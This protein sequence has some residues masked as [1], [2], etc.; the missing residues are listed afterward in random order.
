MFKTI[1]TTLTTLLLLSGTSFAATTAGRTDHSG[2][3]VWTFLGF[4]ALIVVAQLLP[5]LMVILGVV[6]SSSTADEKKHA[7]VHAK[8]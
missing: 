5:A 6:K 4:C 7:A 8:K 3:L 1:I 2:I